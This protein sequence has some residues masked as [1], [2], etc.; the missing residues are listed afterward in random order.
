MNPLI[1]N[2]KEEAINIITHFIG[3]LLAIA[4]TFYLLFS[5]QTKEEL[6]SYL[7]YGFSAGI[8]YLMST[9]YHSASKPKLRKIFKIAD[10]AAIYLFIAGTYT[11]FILLK[12]RT[13]ASEKLLLVVWLLAL[14]GV[15]LKCFLTGRFK[16]IS[17]LIY[18]AMGWLIIVLGEE[19]GKNLTIECILC[20]IAGGLSYSLGSFFYLFKRIP[21]HHGIWHLFVLA[22]SSFHFFA[23][24][25]S[26]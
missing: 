13:S 18:L 19:L 2:K 15:I 12:F 14:S 8:L 9:L 3:F 4:G 5:A 7:I 6:V 22:G 1:Y 17:T 26:H 25:V 20:L 10:H 16:L 23:L 21:Y 24:L 11:P